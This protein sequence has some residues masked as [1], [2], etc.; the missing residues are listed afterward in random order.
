MLNSTNRRENYLSHYAFAGLVSPQIIKKQS[1]ALNFVHN[2]Q[3]FYGE[4]F[5][6]ASGSQFGNTSLSFT[7]NF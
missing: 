7:Q 4:S 6:A 5:N 1:L 2:Q 3:Q